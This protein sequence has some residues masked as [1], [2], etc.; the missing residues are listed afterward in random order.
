MCVMCV[1]Q[2]P[3]AEHVVPIKDFELEAGEHVFRSSE[4]GLK[5]L[6]NPNLATLAVGGKLSKLQLPDW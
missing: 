2:I 6:W 3:R 1:G 4:C 5:T